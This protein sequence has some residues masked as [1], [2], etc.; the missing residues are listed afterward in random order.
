M[1]LLRVLLGAHPGSRH[2]QGSAAAWEPVLWMETVARGREIGQQTQEHCCH[3]APAL[4]SWLVPVGRG[5][6]GST[7]LVPAPLH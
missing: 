7:V 6:S 5:D 1:H 2:M 3:L 4:A